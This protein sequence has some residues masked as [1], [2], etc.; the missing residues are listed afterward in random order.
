VVGS[1]QSC[2]CPGARSGELFALPILLTE[3]K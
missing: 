2:G 1:T 3:V